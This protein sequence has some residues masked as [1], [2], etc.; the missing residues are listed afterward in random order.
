[1]TTDD[2][3]VPAAL[4]GLLDQIDSPV[5]LFLAEGAYDGEPTVKALT[6][7]FGALIEIAIPL[8]KNA[9]MSAVVAQNPSIRD[10]HIAEIEAHGRMTWQKSSG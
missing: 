3:G 2:I 4:P 7:R 9:V 8:P 6:D 1:L 10:Q 5:D